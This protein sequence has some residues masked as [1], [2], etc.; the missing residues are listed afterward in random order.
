[1]LI[2]NPLKKFCKKHQKKVIIKNVTE[3][4]TFLLVL[5][6]VKLVLRITIFGAFF[7]NVFNGFEISVKFCVFYI[8][9]IKKNCLVIL[10]LFE[11][12][13]DKRA[14]DG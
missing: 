3:I 14:K 4:C 10:A 1:M 2:S 7:K 8:F 11:N 9:L 12:L 13:E 6:F 5:M